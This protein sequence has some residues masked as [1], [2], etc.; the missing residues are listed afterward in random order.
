MLATFLYAD[1][2]GQR[3]LRTVLVNE[4]QC[5]KVFSNSALPEFPY[6]LPP[7][8]YRPTL[9][10]VFLFIDVFEEDLVVLDILG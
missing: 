7:L 9:S 1:L 5:K 2:L 6:E 3:S 10:F 8:S 4:D